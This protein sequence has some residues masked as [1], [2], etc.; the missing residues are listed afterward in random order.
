[1]FQPD[2]KGRVAIVTGASRGI[3]RECA[4]ALA[5]LGCNIV[6]AAKTIEQHPTLPGTIFT[7]AKECEE[8]GV[9][10][11]AIQCDVRKE[12]DI[13]ACVQRTMDNFGRIDILINNAS[14]LWWMDIEETPL[15]KYNLINEVNARGT[16]LM[17]QKVLPHMKKANYGRIIMMSPPLSDKGIGSRTAYHIS[18][19][20]MTIVA[21]GASEETQGYNITANTLW[22]NT[23]VESLASKNFAMGT[24]EMW[25]K[26]S[27][28]SDS[29]LAIIDQDESF[30]GQMLID[31][32]FLRS[33]GVTDF[34]KYQVVP[35]CEPP[36]MEELEK[37]GSRELGKRGRAIVR[38]PTSKL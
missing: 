10:A 9:Q 35:G 17:T 32:D 11:L 12:E 22:P 14:A 36:T 30:S 4:I 38:A 23:V 5:A 24:P 37:A 21:L 31:E 28:L 1:M 19:F 20:G 15:S 13:E 34:T 7:V 26:A 3:G 27:I 29:V 33:I 2:V 18:K 16:F 25:R 6:V 8:L